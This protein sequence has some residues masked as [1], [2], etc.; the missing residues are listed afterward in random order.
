MN[1]FQRPRLTKRDSVLSNYFPNYKLTP[2]YV[3]MDEILP[4]ADKFTDDGAINDSSHSQ[5]PVAPVVVTNRD[6][7]LVI[8]N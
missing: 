5:L 1:S 4:D 8:G 6:R 7:Y 3:E 2:A